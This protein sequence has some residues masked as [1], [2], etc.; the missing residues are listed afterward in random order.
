MTVNGTEYMNSRD[1]CKLSF[2][3][4]RVLG[5]FLGCVNDGQENKKDYNF[6]LLRMQI[7]LENTTEK[8][9]QLRPMRWRK[10]RETL[11]MF[12]S[13]LIQFVFVTEDGNLDQ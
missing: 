7:V 10:I 9:R 1:I 4:G 5:D 11:L 8:I 3:L 6:N 13:T 12:G 2:N